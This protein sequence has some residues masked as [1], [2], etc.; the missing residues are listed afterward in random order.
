V[1]NDECSELVK[2]WAV[3]KY[4]NRRVNFFKSL[5]EDLSKMLATKKVLI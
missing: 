2:N 5:K 3:E 4:A 1:E